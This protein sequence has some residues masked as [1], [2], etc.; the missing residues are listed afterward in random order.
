MV[1]RG[2]L[3]CDGSNNLMHD[4]FFQT[5]KLRCHDD[6]IITFSGSSGGISSGDYIR[7]IRYSTLDIYRWISAPMPWDIL[8]TYTVADVYEVRVPPDPS[9]MV[10]LHL[11]EWVY[12]P[13]LGWVHK[14]SGG[15]G[16]ML[17][18]TNTTIDAGGSWGIAQQTGF[19][20]TMTNINVD[21][22]AYT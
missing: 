19:Y 7:N 1:E 5:Y 6:V 2:Q 3:R 15:T 10:T 20:S 12:L 16:N 14:W 4:S 9:P 11:N 21:R 18:A 22:P 13:F 8:N 17:T